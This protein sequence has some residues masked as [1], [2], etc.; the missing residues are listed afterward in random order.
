MKAAPSLSQS[1]GPLREPRVA[2]FPRCPSVG[3]AQ[4]PLLMWDALFPPS[5]RAHPHALDKSLLPAGLLEGGPACTLCFTLL[6]PR[7]AN[8]KRKPSD[9]LEI[10]SNQKPGLTTPGWRWVPL[11]CWVSC[12]L[13]HLCIG[14]VLLLPSTPHRSYL[15]QGK[16][17]PPCPM[18]DSQYLPFELCFSCSHLSPTLPQAH[19]TYPSPRFLCCSGTHQPY[20]YPRAFALADLSLRMLFPRYPH[21]LIPHLTQISAQMSPYQRPSLPFYSREI[22]IFA[23]PY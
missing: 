22:S 13:S 6:G 19:P 16:I 5:Q 14:P 1:A 12:C 15:A 8:G 17:Q 2:G 7:L 11:P 20:S 9:P 4:G 23:L 18:G 3:A 21:A 10:C